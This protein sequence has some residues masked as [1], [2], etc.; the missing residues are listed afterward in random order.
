MLNELYHLSNTLEKQGLLPHASTH[1]DVHKL[2]KKEC[3]YI[4]L[5]EEG[6]PKSLRLLNKEEAYRLFV[7]SNGNHDRFPAIKVQ[8]PLLPEAISRE[9]DEKLWE[10][11]DLEKKRELL[12]GLDYSAGNPK[13]NDIQIKPWTLEQM[14]PVLEDTEDERLDAVRRLLERFPRK[15][16]TERFYAALRSLIRDR[17]WNEGETTIKFLKS[18]LVGKYDPKKEQYTADCGCYFDIYELS[19]VEYAVADPETEKALIEVLL[20]SQNE[21]ETSLD[22]AGGHLGIS[23]LSG[24]RTKLVRDKYPNPKMQVIGPAYLY[25][26]NTGASPCLLR[27][28]MEG[29][30]AFPAGEGQVRKMSDALSFLMEDARQ[31]FTWTSFWGTSGKQPLLLLA[32]LEDDPRCEARLAEALGSE[33]GTL[34]YVNLCKKALDILKLKLEADPDDPV[35]LQLFEILDTGRKQIAYSRTMRVADLY[36]NVEEWLEASENIPNISFRG[37]WKDRKGNEIRYIRPF[38]PGPGAVSRLLRTQYR[39]QHNGSAGTLQDRKACLLTEEEIY[40]L[41]LPDT[42]GNR[43]DERL[44]EICMREVL[45]TCGDLMFD[46]ARFQTMFEK[47]HPFSLEVLNRACAA[48]KLLGILLCRSGIRKEEYMK[49]KMFL[50]GRYMKLADRLHRNYCIIERNGETLKDYSKPLPG[51]MMGSAVYSMAIQRPKMAFNQLTEKM[52]LYQSWASNNQSSQ[53]GWIVRLLEKTVS[54]MDETD[55]DF[56]EKPTDNDRAELNFGFMSQLPYM[57]GK[58]SNNAAEETETQ[59]EAEL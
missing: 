15:E 10:K 11:A 33:G 50:L 4:S 46:A 58:N 28:G 48:V 1:R 55:S 17:L 6:I 39:T 34:M 3:L 32:W 22:E 51:E 2:A 23:A 56:P 18:L 8:K 43:S 45:R 47:K 59:E 53:S 9:F 36:R 44:I 52:K 14:K 16:D 38:C 13:S 5:N 57:G 37:N 7:H 41:F 31:G 21:M 35:H 19:Q 30:N 42:Y 49:S 54:E 12:L 24:T 25:S 26:N 40:R 29:T 20:A 27:Y